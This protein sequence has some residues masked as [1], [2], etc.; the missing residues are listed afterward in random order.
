MDT[1]VDLHD[2]G[3]TYS[4]KRLPKL[5]K[6]ILSKTEDERKEQRQKLRQERFDEGLCTKCGEKQYIEGLS[7]CEDC[8]VKHLR[9]AV[10]R[11]QERK[12]KNL[13][14]GCGKEAI[15]GLSRCEDCNVKH[16]FGEKKKREQRIEQSLCIECGENPHIEGGYRCEDCR[17][18]NYTRGAEK[19]QELLD[20]GLCTRCGEKKLVEGRNACQEADCLDEGS[21]RTAKLQ[22]ERLD[23]GLCRYCG[24]K[25]HTEDTQYCEG[26][27]I[28]RRY[29]GEPEKELQANIKTLFENL[30][31]KIVEAASGH[32]TKGHPD[33]TIS[34]R[35]NGSTQ[36][37]CFEIKTN[38]GRLSGKAQEEFWADAVPNSHG[39]LTLYDQFGTPTDYLVFLP[40]DMEFVHLVA[41]CENELPT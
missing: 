35:K 20:K 3:V 1:I 26:C 18:K 13:C 12:I 25:E 17:N 7:R 5:P 11:R 6:R 39:V 37:F 34:R 38:S 22:K 8:N 23:K 10:E 15:K 36:R 41:N 33:L 14:I 30:G 4:A 28:K 9:D 19:R 32:F 27:L 24:K 21:K 2:R 40:K 29:N 31:W 16:V